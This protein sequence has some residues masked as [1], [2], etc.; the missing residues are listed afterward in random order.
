VDLRTVTVRYYFTRDGSAAVNAVCDWAQAGCANVTT[1][2]V[3]LPTPVSGADSYLEVG[4]T[5]GSV[6]A[7]ADTGDIQLRLNKADWSAFNEADDY[8]R[9]A[10]P[11]YVDAPR[12]PAY[13]GGALAWGTAP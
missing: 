3:T 13:A 10:Q 5:A 4:F 2:V 7:G 1:R 9:A 11:S 8:S 12:I 6:A